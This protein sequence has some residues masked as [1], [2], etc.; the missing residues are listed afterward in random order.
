MA[1]ESVILNTTLSFNAYI[2]SLN[3]TTSVQ[4]QT[5]SLIK[6]AQALTVYQGLFIVA[7]LFQF[8]LAVDAVINWLS[9]LSLPQ[10]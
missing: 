10:Y 8:V 2:S 3:V 1:L 9:S 7:Q 6:N 5:T 4:L